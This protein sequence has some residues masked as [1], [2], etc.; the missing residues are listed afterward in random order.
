MKL[1]ELLPLEVY[2]YTLT[3]LHSERPKLHSFGHSECNRV[4]KAAQHR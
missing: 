3:L 1:Q 2:Q 4:K